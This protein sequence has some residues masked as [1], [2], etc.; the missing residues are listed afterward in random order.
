LGP[1][2]LPRVGW[3]LDGAP[4]HGSGDGSYAALAFDDVAVV[5]KLQTN[6]GSK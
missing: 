3:T 2:E 5:L 4:H 6:K 1:D